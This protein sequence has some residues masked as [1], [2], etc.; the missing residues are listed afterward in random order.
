PATKENFVEAE[1]LLA[2]PDVSRAIESGAIESGFKHFMAFGRNENRQLRTPSIALTEMKARKLN[3]LRHLIRAE[4][5]YTESE[6]NFNFLTPERRVSSAI[7]DTDNVSAHRYD[8]SA[9]EI[10]QRHSNGLVLDVG[11]GKRPEYFEHVVNFEIV[12]YDSTDVVGV[13]EVLP[14]K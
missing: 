14:F 5:E 2:N 8:A 13:S 11:A 6:A 12:E 3:R 9:M 4:L 1:Y 7:V 10:I